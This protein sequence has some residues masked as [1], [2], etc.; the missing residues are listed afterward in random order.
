MQI[1]NIQSTEVLDSRGNPT[2]CTTLTLADG[3]V[4]MGM[5]PSGASTG[6][7]EAAE[8]RDSDSTRYGGLGVLDVIESIHTEVAPAIVGRDFG[9][10]YDLDQ[11]LVDL[12]GSANFSRLGA[13]A[14]L[15]ISLAYARAVA[16][17]SGI[18]LYQYFEMHLE[19]HPVQ[20]SFPLPF[21]NVVNGGK[22]ADSGL[23]IQEFM[24]VP[25]GIADYPRQLQA[26]SEISHIL[27]QILA[28]HALATGV[29]DE[30]GYAPR[31]D[32]TTQVFDFL[33]QA[34]SQA[35]Y[36]AGSEV[37]IALDV[38]ATSF[39]QASSQ[40]YLLTPEHQTLTTEQLHDTYQAWVEAYPIV[41]IE[42]PFH[43]EDFAAFATLRTTLAARHVGIVG[44]DLTVTNVER[45]EEA[46]SH[47]S[48]TTLLVKPN[49]IGTLSGTFD[50]INL[51]HKHNIRTIISHR[52]G[53][54][55]DDSIADLAVAAGS[56]GLKAG[57]M[58]RGER[59]AKYN[60][61]SA[62]YSQLYPGA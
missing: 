23:A 55:L 59:L 41:S 40:T 32:S 18:S 50:A 58:T 6:S 13:N 47:K 7:H 54:T 37:A 12:D 51:A 26:L 44:D 28:L 2:V 20:S 4:G 49:Q 21:A 39:Y 19:R 14:A 1:Q 5:V 38:A 9:S 53:E 36:T 43:E 15:S 27:K 31:V 52:S 42:D 8:R 56:Y 61:L 48:I 16:T 46:L 17:S 25:V 35:G 11:M 24:L 34:I 45:L 10:Q 29:G 62:I 60:R 30:G 33:L 57:G 3:S 22:H